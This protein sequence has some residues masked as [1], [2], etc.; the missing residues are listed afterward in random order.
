MPALIPYLL[1]SVIFCISDTYTHEDLL[2]GDSQ[3]IKFQTIA[4]QQIT[5]RDKGLS[6]SKNCAGTH[7][8]LTNKEHENLLFFINN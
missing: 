2:L 3:R 6:A 4:R 5:K 1:F 8:L 7:R